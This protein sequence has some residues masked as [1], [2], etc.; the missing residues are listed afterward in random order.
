MLDFSMGEIGLIAAVAL[1]VLGPDKLPQVA[2]TAGSLMGKAQ[3]FVS[4]VKNDIDKEIEL[5][6]L[7]KIQEDAKKMASDLQDNL[8]NTQSQI[9]KEV[10]DLNKSVES[11]GKNIQEQ[12]Q[13]ATSEINSVKEQWLSDTAPK[14]TDLE[15]SIENIVEG[16]SPAES[17]KVPETKWSITPEE[18]DTSKLEGAFAWNDPFD[19]DFT[20]QVPADNSAETLAAKTD[21]TV[22]TVE[23]AETK[24]EALSKELESLKAVVLGNTRLS[25]RAGRPKKHYAVSRFGTASRLN[26]ISK[27]R[28][29]L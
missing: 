28:I 22:A 29:N 2:K 15:A 19:T 24:L 20:P 18:V 4:Q 13:Q 26:R 16:G 23:D 27:K 11:V 12:A 1:V 14:N 17:V 5:S 7:K 8:K 9:E 10:N 6:E 3:R 25:A 21:R